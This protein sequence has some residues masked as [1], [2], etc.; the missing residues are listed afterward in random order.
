MARMVRKQVYLDTR[1]DELLKSAAERT[2]K[3][4]SELIREAIDAVHD[5][6]AVR[7]EREKAWVRWREESEEFAQWVAD[8]GGIEPWDRDSLYADRIDRLTRILDKDK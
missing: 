6:E 1:Q 8:R 5:P 2:G 4:E 7:T 3:T